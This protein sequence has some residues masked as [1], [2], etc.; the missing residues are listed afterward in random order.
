MVRFCER[1]STSP[2]PRYAAPCPPCSLALPPQDEWWSGKI[3][4]QRGYF[5]KAYVRLT[6]PAIHVIR[7]P[8]SAAIAN[9]HATLFPSAAEAAEGAVSKTIKQTEMDKKRSAILAAQGHKESPRKPQE[10][11]EMDDEKQ[12]AEL[13]K[14][15]QRRK[16]KEGMMR[17]QQRRKQKNDGGADG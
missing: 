7:R 4:E 1:L 15:E 6:P 16:L 5:P 2:G 8:E 9:L 12:L 17:Q 11:T 10:E 13:R 3:G 14:Q